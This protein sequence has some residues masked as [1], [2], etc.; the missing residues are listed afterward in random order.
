MPLDDIAWRISDLIFNGCFSSTL[1]EQLAGELVKARLLKSSHRFDEALEVINRSLD[2]LPDYP[3]ALFLKA[4][5]LWEGYT[6]YSGARACLKK[7]IQMKKMRNEQEKT[8]RRWCE[9]MLK[10]MLA[11]KREQQKRADRDMR[12]G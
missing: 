7:V 8:V 6:D 12:R 5:I 1:H 9:N 2:R 11:E 10:E 4:Q 3:E